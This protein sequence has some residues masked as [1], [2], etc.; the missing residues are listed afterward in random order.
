MQNW[1]DEFQTGPNLQRQTFIRVGYNWGYERVFAREFGLNSF[2]NG[3][4]EDS[5][6]SKNVFAYAG[7][8]PSKKYSF[9]YFI[10]YRWGEHDFD[11]GAGPR[12]PRVSP[13]ALLDP[14]APLD[15][16]AGNLFY[17]NGNITYKFTN[18]LNMTLS[19]NKNRLTRRDTGRVSFDSNIVSLKTTYQF[20]RFLFARARVDYNSLVS[21]FRG[22]FLFGWTPNP[23]TAFYVGYNDD[24]NRNFFNPF[25]GQLEP[26]FRRNGR[27]FFIKM[28]YLFRKS[29]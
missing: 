18:D 6:R 4:G 22:Q 5:V 29:F 1:N 27:T 25:T 28:S 19:F 9:F 3:R 17:S 23:G 11:F 7:S 15:P 24:I 16:G 10:A 13:A 14:N 26:G 2:A 12:F 8:T 21:N 20:T